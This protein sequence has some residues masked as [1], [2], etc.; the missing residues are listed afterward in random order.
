M[1]DGIPYMV[2]G[3]GGAARYDFKTPVPGSAV[4]YNAD[5][6]AQ[7]VT[8]SDTAMTFEFY[9]VTGTLVDSYLIPATGSDGE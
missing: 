2:N 4:R 9:D 8:V 5:W 3:L 1:R 7:K 6:G